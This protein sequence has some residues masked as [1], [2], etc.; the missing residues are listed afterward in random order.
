VCLA[1]E[2]VWCVLTFFF[3]RYSR[4]LQTSESMSRQAFMGHSDFRRLVYERNLC[5]QRLTGRCTVRVRRYTIIGAQTGYRIR[6]CS[7]E[8]FSRNGDAIVR[9][10]PF[11]KRD[12]K[13]LLCVSCTSA[14]LH[15]YFS[16]TAR[17]L[18]LHSKHWLTGL[19]VIQ[20]MTTV[21]SCIRCCIQY[22]NRIRCRF[23]MNSAC[24][25]CR[26]FRWKNMT[27]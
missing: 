4:L 23:F 22:L 2:C 1:A 7:P 6:D 11:M 15:V 12:L 17:T 9:L 3:Y 13:V 24:S 26:H 27:R 16:V 5:A 18:P 25:R 10:I 20:S 14:W 8:F 21:A 19:S